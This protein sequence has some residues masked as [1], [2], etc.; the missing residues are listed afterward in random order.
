MRPVDRRRHGRYFLWRDSSASRR[1]DSTGRD[2]VTTPDVGKYAELGRRLEN[3]GI[4][5]DRGHGLTS[6]MNLDRYRQEAA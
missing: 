4:E 1:W 5:A 2:P 3:M 6:E